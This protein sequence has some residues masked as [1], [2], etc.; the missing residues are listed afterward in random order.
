MILLFAK[1]YTLWVVNEVFSKCY[2]AKKACICKEGVLII[3]DI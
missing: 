3:E 1:V 2:K